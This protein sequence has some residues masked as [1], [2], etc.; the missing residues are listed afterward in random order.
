MRVPVFV[1]AGWGCLALGYLVLAHVLHAA[2]A[3]AV[4]LS[5]GVHTPLWAIAGAAALLLLRVLVMFVAPAVALA[6]LAGLLPRGGKHEAKPSEVAEQARSQKATRGN[7][8]ASGGGR[9]A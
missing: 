1:L 3:G 8:R 4:L 2:H 5:S 7:R 6:S 9:A